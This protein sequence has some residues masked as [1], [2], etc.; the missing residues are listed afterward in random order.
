V[1]HIPL[2]VVPAGEPRGA[3]SRGEPSNVVDV[4]PTILALAGIEEPG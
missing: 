3:A 1:L 2:L 4:A